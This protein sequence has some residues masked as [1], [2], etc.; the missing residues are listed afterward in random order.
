MIV[1]ISKVNVKV[2]KLQIR[3]HF[4]FISFSFISSRFFNDIS[5]QLKVF[6]FFV[7]LDSE[8]SEVSDN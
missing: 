4:F 6:E 2:T 7:H 1:P 5:L 8:D 3:T